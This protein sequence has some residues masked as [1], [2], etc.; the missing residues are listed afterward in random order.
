MIEDKMIIG[1]G[2]TPLT[3]ADA[4]IRE[5][6]DRRWLEDVIYFIQAYIDRTYTSDI[7]AESEEEE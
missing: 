5:C 3:V 7:E 1:N 2:G 6:A 4:V